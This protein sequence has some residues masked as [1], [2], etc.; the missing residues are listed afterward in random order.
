MIKKSKAFLE[1][2]PSSL[3]PASAQK[4]KRRR[5]LRKSERLTTIMHKKSPRSGLVLVHIVLDQDLKR[6]VIRPNQSMIDDPVFAESFW[7]PKS[8]TDAQIFKLMDIGWRLG[9]TYASRKRTRDLLEST[10]QHC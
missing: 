2:G 5:P 8:L 10:R 4:M 1:R 9:K 7:C 3:R 6:R